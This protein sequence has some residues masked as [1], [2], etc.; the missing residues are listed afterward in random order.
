MLAW[1]ATTHSFH[2]S[3]ARSISTAKAV[4]STFAKWLPLRA[5]CRP[6]RRVCHGPRRSPRGTR[7]EAEETALLGFGEFGRLLFGGLRVV[8]VE[9]Q[10]QLFHGFGDAG[11]RRMRHQRHAV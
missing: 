1:V 9:L 8:A 7:Q 11:F 3:K 4:A 2:S 6:R 5:R 10:R